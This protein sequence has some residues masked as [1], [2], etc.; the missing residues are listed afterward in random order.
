MS[1]NEVEQRAR[2]LVHGGSLSG[3]LESLGE[4]GQ[5]IDQRED[6]EGALPF[7][8]LRRFP[9]KGL[10]HAVILK[11]LEGGLGIRRKRLLHR[12]LHDPDEGIAPSVPY[13]DEPGD[14]VPNLAERVVNLRRV[15][16]AVVDNVDR[17]PDDVI[18]TH[19]LEPERLDT[20]RA[21][22]DLGVPQEEP[23][24]EGLVL[25]LGPA[26]RV[27]QKAEHVLLSA[28][29]PG[30]LSYPALRRLEVRREFSHDGEKIEVVEAGV[31]DPVDGPY[32]RVTSEHLER[33]FAARERLV[34]CLG[35]CLGA[36]PIERVLGDSRQAARLAKAPI[37]EGVSLTFQFQ[38][39]SSGHRHRCD[40]PG[41]YPAVPGLLPVLLA[42]VPERLKR[43]ERLVR[44]SPKKLSA[45]VG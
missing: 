14:D 34:K 42:V 44:R 31:V 22:S 39:E 24:C 40:L 41:R 29:E 26:G 7:R 17:V 3:E 33:L 27:D 32:R 25:D 45:C 20:D 6:G 4:A 10:R 28:V 19:R 43:F 23:R 8:D 18:L 9:G 13:L 30:P 37:V 5:R 1:A 2:L 11:H 21:P 38:S 15:L 35:G 36:Q 16:P 12:V